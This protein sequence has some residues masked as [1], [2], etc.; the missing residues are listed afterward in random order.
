[1]RTIR[2]LCAVLGLAGLAIGALGC[3]TTEGFGED[4][5]RGGERLSHEAR[6]HR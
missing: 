1:M 6:E 2:T 4:L 3:R 5:Q